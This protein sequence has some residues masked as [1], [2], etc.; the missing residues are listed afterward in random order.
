VIGVARP[1][2]YAEPTIHVSVRMPSSLVQALGTPLSEKIVE[3][4]RKG[5]GATSLAPTGDGGSPTAPP[6]SIRCP[7]KNTTNVTKGIV[8]RDCG[9]FV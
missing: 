8:C 9:D 3:A 4:V 5:V 2:K 1:Q 7:H 6:P